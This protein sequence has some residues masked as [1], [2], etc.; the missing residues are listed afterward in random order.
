MVLIDIP[1]ENIIHENKPCLKD[2]FQRHIT[3]YFLNTYVKRNELTFGA[4]L[5]KNIVNSY[6]FIPL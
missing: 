6:V 1:L 3:H 4:H 5:Y 2:E